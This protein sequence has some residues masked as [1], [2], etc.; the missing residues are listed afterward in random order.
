MDKNLPKCRHCQNTTC[1]CI[2]TCKI[3]VIF[4]FYR[5]TYLSSKRYHI[6]PISL[7]PKD[8]TSWVSRTS[9]RFFRLTKWWARRTVSQYG[10]T[11]EE[12]RLR[13]LHLQWGQRGARVNQKQ[14]AGGKPW[15][16]DAPKVSGLKFHC[17]F[18]DKSTYACI[19]VR[20]VNSKRTN[21]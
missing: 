1:Q 16:N 8:W 15:V 6:P 17:L 20:N 14:P 21:E 11:Q 10:F 19:H 18:F 2:S 5:Y 4:H 7:H 12:K 9:V 13:G 3:L